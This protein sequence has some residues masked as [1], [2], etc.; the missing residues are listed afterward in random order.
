MRF[1]LYLLLGALLCLWT[2]VQFYLFFCTR[3]MVWEKRRAEKLHLFD[4]KSRH[5]LN[6]WKFLRGSGGGAGDSIK[7]VIRKKEP[8]HDSFMFNSESVVSG[9]SAVCSVRYQDKVP[10]V[11]TCRNAS[12]VR[13]RFSDQI[14]IYFNFTHRYVEG[15]MGEKQ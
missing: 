11:F 9:C 3:R 8:T 10:S 7:G 6:T 2:I 14:T 4:A 5:L 15:H 1:F 12:Q 13:L